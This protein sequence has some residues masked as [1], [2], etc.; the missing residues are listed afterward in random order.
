MANSITL[1]RLQSQFLRELAKIVNKDRKI[2]NQP[3]FN[4]TEVKI[5]K[6]YSFATVYY[7]IL[8]DEE[9]DLKLAED[10]LEKIKGSIKYELSQKMK[11]IRKMP[12]LKFKFDEA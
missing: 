1:E 2:D 12:D 8:S 4:I 10:I 9:K 11:N 6:D 3:Y 5:T 7:T